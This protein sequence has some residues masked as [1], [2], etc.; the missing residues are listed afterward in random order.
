VKALEPKLELE[1]EVD[2]IERWLVFEGTYGRPEYLALAPL[3]IFD[4]EERFLDCEI[5]Y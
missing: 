4:L 3:T 2:E 5:A 1:G